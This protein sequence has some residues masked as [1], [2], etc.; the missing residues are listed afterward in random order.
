MEEGQLALPLGVDA[1]NDQMGARGGLRVAR[2][3]AGMRIRKKLVFLHTCFSLVLAGMLALALRPAVREVVARAEAHEAAALARLLGGRGD[4][5]GGAYPDTVSVLRGDALA[6][7]LSDEEAARLQGA[8]GGVVELGE[9]GDAALGAR[10]GLF[11]GGAGD[12]LVVSVRLESAR[13][14]VVRLYVAMTL[15]LLAVYALVAAALEVFV[16]PEH[17]YEPIRRLLDADRAVQEGRR[18]EELI[19]EGAMPRDELGE[20]MR[21]R[22]DSI[23]AMRRHERDLGAALGRLEEVATDLKRKNYLLEA[24]RRNLADAD[25][26]ASL[27]VMS[28][29]LAHEMNTPLAVLKGMVEKLRRGN[30]AGLSV[31]EAQLMGRVVSRLEGLSESLLDFARVRPPQTRPADVRAL[32]E[33]AWTLVSL[34]REAKGVGFEDR[35]APGL[36][37]ECDP[38]RIVQVLV[39]LLRNAV[40]AMGGGGN[41]AGG[42]AMRVEVAAQASERDGREWMSITVSDTGPGIDPEVL[43]RLFEPFAST[44]LD[45]RGTGLGLAV[46]EGIVSEHGGL[47]LARNRRDAGG[48]AP[49]AVFEIVLPCRRGDAPAGGGRGEAAVDVGVG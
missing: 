31:A 5:A 45:S 19:P 23:S 39:N 36:V 33:E 40:D 3:L 25:R 48:G 28:A 2:V 7:G 1:R 26:L 35:V 22:N 32:V 6:V 29:G 37:V 16:L 49:G 9:S 44:R 8:A 30:G 18:E 34:D 14:A 13:R 4:V 11:D 24:A 12:F 47:L 43:P 17:V 41:A 15:A 20:I 10:A 27:G 42:A 21:S 46:S 38:D